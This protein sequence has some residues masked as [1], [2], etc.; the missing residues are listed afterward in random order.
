MKNI[1]TISI[2]IKKKK[3]MI[4]NKTPWRYTTILI[5]KNLSPCEIYTITFKLDFDVL[6]L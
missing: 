4:G 3:I 6:K 2:L 1:Y 5:F